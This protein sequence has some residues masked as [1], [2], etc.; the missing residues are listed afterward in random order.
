MFFTTRILK[1]PKPTDC[2]W[3][4]VVRYQFRKRTPTECI[5]QPFGSWGPNLN[6]GCK[7]LNQRTLT[8][9]SLVKPNPPNTVSTNAYYNIAHPNLT[10]FSGVCF[11]NQCQQF[12][13]SDID[14]MVF[15]L[16]QLYSNVKTKNLKTI[17][18]H[19]LQNI[20]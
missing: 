11:L 18:H 15:L 12:Y 2:N 19:Q 6:S 17:L 1:W 10:N 8:V 14:H 5:C 13:W 4:Y 9:C 20:C 7:R 3:R 16:N